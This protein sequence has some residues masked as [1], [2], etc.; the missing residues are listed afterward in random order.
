MIIITLLS[1][2]L[3]ICGYR[4]SKPDTKVILYVRNECLIR[5][6]FP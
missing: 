1:L 2:S 5:E 4:P 6:I 3:T